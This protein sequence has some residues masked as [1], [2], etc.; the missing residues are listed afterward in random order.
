[1]YIYMTQQ[2]QTFYRYIKSPQGC[3]RAVSTQ[4]LNEISMGEWRLRERVRAG[5]ALH[6]RLVKIL[7]VHRCG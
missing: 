2:E 6:N 5:A 7:D 3:S 4:E 1:M